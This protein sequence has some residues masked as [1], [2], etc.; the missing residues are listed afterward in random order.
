[1]GYHRDSFCELRRAFQVGGTGALVEEKRG[2]RG[3]HP[4]RGSP[5]VEEAILKYSLDSPRHRREP[6]PDLYQR[7]RT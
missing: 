7:A 6:D 5:E 1:M 3:P 2:P 4:N